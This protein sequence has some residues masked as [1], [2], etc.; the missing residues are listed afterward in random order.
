[1]ATIRTAADKITAT[2]A[3]FGKLKE[4]Q[5][6]EGSYQS[7]LFEGEGLPDGKLWRAMDPDQAQ[8]FTRGQTVY[9]VPTTNTKGKPSYDIELIAPA[10][11]P[12]TPAT[13]QGTSHQAPAN[14]REAYLETLERVGNRYQA[15]ITKAKQI[16]LTQYSEDDLTALPE[17]LHTTAT[18]LFIEANRM[19]H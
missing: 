12:T 8:S 17:L 7:V 2:V 16:W 3:G 18:T 6:N 14:A 11:A 10:T 1:M 15:C 4:S 13:A 5:F 19:T 9:L